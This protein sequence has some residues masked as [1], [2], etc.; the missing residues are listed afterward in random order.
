MTGGVHERL[1]RLV[2]ALIGTLAV[3]FAYLLARRMAG[4]WSNPLPL[5]AQRATKVM[6][7]AAAR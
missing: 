1:A 2:L 7:L 3:W 5:V 6:G 4:G